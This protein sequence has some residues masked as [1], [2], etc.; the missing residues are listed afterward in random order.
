MEIRKLDYDDHSISFDKV[1]FSDFVEKMKS[2]CDKDALIS[3][4]GESLTINNPTY[5]CEECE[6]EGFVYAD[7]CMTPNDCCQGCTKKVDC[8]L[9]KGEGSL[10]SEHYKWKMEI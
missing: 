8:D 6:G 2:L 4:D 9:C 3:F 7:D 1:L 10:E 5:M